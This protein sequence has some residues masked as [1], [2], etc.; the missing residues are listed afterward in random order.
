[1][2]LNKDQ[3]VIKKEIF[4]RVKKFY[5]IEKSKEKFIPGVSKIPYAGRI[6]DE[7]EIISL[8]DSALEFWLTEG[9]FAKKFNRDFCNFLNSKYSVLTNSGSSANLLALSALT[10]TK[11]GDK[12][13]QKGDEII[14]IAA[15]FPTTINPIIQIGAIP[16]LLDL[17]LE[18]Y[19]INGQ[20]IEESITNKTKAIILAHTLGN[21]FNIPK[22]LEIVED[23]DLFLV[24]DCCDALGS[25][26]NDKFV[27]NF[28]I[29]GTFSFYP[30]HHITMGEGGAVI[31]N[32]QNIYRIIKSFRDW[33]RD[34]WCEPGQDNSCGKRFG[35]KL[36]DL[37]FGY[38]HKYI[39][40]HIGYNLK[41]VDLQPAIGLEQ[42][43]KLPTFI[44]IRRQ[45][46][47]Y[48]YNFFKKFSNM[49]Y[50]PKS[51]PNAEPSWF[52]FILTLKENSPFSKNEI[53]HFLENNRIATRPLFSGNITRQPAYTSVNFRIIDDLKNTDYIMNN[54]FWFGVY[55]GISTEMRE[56]IIKKFEEFLRKYN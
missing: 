2:N 6:Y 45:N 28:G 36:G 44:E 47:E 21:P 48:F 55:P 18:T 38:D 32:N 17:N 39:Y 5:L 30:A 40:S 37:P 10:S 9:R 33:G 54:S 3:E 46:F 22:I 14:T 26:F 34:C 43:K 56:Y 19:N 8:I 52:G 4:E 24:E 42:L 49:F 53:V 31:T 13:I 41:L 12:R 29:I 50:L 27:G 23:Y 16:V 35:W 20:K 11:L 15:S 51:L 7:N 25:K 1:M